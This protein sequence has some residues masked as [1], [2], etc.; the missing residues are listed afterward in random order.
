MDVVQNTIHNLRGRI[1]ITSRPGQGTHIT[2]VIPLTL[3]F[4]ESMIVRISDCLY[5]VPIDDVSEI[6]QLDEKSTV[7]SSASGDVVIM[8]Q[9]KPIPLVSLD[10]R[11]SNQDLTNIVVVAQTS[12]GQIGL[13]MDE[14]LGQQQVVMK[15]LTGHLKDI[16]GGAG[17]ALLSSGEVAIALDVEQLFKDERAGPQA[18]D[19]KG[20]NE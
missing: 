13:L 6:L 14:V 5:A 20:K 2:L 10:D 16:R 12:H 8:R 17:C 15:P 1:E 18:D 4:L 19:S 9:G 11:R 7:R 3:A